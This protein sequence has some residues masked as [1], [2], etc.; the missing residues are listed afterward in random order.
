MARDALR[1]H[2]VHSKAYRPTEKCCIIYA[3]LSSGNLMCA[4]KIEDKTLDNVMMSVLTDLLAPGTN[5]VRSGQGPNAE[6]RGVLIELAD[7]K[8]RVSFALA[9]GVFISALAE[10]LWYMTGQSSP[11]FMKY[12][13]PKYPPKALASGYG[14]RLFDQRGIS[15]VD[16]IIS[17]LKKGESDTRRGVVQIYNAEDFNADDYQPPCTLNFQFIPREGA[18]HMATTMRSNDAWLG[19]PHDV[20]AFTMLQEYIASRVGLELGSYQHFVTCMHLYEKDMEGARAYVAE[21]F[22]DVRSMPSM[23]KA[24]SDDAV[25]TV[26]HCEEQL[27]IEGKMPSVYE[28]LDPYWRDLVTLL[29]LHN[30]K[31]RRRFEVFDNVAARISNDFFGP[32]VAK[33]RPKMKEK[34]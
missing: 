19:L 8:A 31:H 22:Q 27:R 4:L 17:K 6:R 28:T 24:G 21:R 29:D 20:F 15:Q 34:S 30:L 13:L 33:I 14:P 3:G 18:L 7:P 25:R 16:Q 32:V 26:L 1:T 10:F 23:P 9:K 12:Y 11:D 2:T 5:R